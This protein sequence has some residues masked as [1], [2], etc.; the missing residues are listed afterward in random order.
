MNTFEIRIT[1]GTAAI[2][3]RRKKEEKTGSDCSFS[4]IEQRKAKFKIQHYNKLVNH[5]S[6]EPLFTIEEYMGNGIEHS[7]RCRKCDTVIKDRLTDGVT[8]RCYT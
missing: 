6:Y 3:T 4:S 8:F 5:P 2:R 7:F 1:R